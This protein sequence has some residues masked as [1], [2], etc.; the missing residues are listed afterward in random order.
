MYPQDTAY[1]GSASVNQITIRTELVPA[2]LRMLGQYAADG[3]YAEDRRY[4]ASVRRIVAAVSAH[5]PLDM[6][7]CMTSERQELA[8]ELARPGL[9][10]V[11][12]ALRAMIH[13]E[14]DYLPEDM[15]ADT[16][17]YLADI[18]AVG[19]AIEGTPA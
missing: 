4:A 12:F 1:A 13:D 16:W 2:T 15:T 5:Q 11:A 17:R 10:T 8:A 19:V 14:F 18:A 9:G 7:A 3:R 6:A